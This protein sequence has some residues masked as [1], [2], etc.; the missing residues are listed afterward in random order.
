MDWFIG[1]T[2]FGHRNIVL[3]E[4]CRQKLGKTTEER[5]NELI[6]RINKVVSK[7]DKLYVLGDFCL[8]SKEYCKNCLDKINGTK[9]LIM[10]N[11]DKVRSQKFFINVGF[12]WV[13]PLPVIYNNKYL[14]SHEP[15]NTTEYINI[16]AH[17]HSRG[18][19]TPT[20]FCTSI[21]CTDLKPVSIQTIVKK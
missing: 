8:K 18:F 12:S 9:I 1:D 14:L 7:I 2:H 20:S 4:P 13:S 16:H 21:E 15:V 5:D 17:S 6:R 19:C 11:H 3:Y 10:G